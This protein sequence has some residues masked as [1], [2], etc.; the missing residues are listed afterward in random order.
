M[1]RVP[2]DDHVRAALAVR[3]ESCPDGCGLSS[4]LCAS[5][6]SRLVALASA[7]LIQPAQLSDSCTA[8]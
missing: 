7:H 3:G 4:D 1:D 6:H 5:L 8:C 2:N